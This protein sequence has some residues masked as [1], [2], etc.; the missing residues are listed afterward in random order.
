[1]RYKLES[2]GEVLGVFRTIKH[3]ADFIGVS[4]QFI[5]ATIGN[6]EFKFQKRNYKIVDR[7]SE[8]S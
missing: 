6:G 4:R 5:Y 3:I 8:L 7:L 1:M 2:N